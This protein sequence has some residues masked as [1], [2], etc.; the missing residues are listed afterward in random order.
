MSCEA[1]QCAVPRPRTIPLLPT[2]GITTSEQPRCISHI[3]L[4]EG[5]AFQGKIRRT[6]LS[7]NLRAFTNNV[8]LLERNAISEYCSEVGPG[9]LGGVPLKTGRD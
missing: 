5:E 7:S 4:A 6:S 9:R 1:G 8:S 3:L 2:S